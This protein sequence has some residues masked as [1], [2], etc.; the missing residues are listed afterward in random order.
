MPKINEVALNVDWLEIK[1][2]EEDWHEIGQKECLKLLNHMHL[3]RAFEE[4]MLSLDKDPTV[5]TPLC[6]EP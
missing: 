1:A 2:S 5:V 4:T 6:R 3:I